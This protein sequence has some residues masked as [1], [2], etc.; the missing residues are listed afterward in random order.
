MLSGR[1]TPLCP[2]GHL[3]LKGGDRQDAGAFL[4]LKPL[5]RTGHYPI[6]SPPLRGRC[7]AGQRG[8]SRSLSLA[9]C[10]LLT[11]AAATSLAHAQS[12]LGIGSAEPGFSATGTFGSL[13][14]WINAQQQGFYRLMTGALRDMR[15]NPWAASTLVA[16]SFGY[17]V[18][19]AAGPGHGKAVISSYMLANE[20]ELKRG[21][22]L[23]FLSS[24][25]QGIVAILLVGAAFLFLRGTTVSMTDAT[26]ALETGSY[27][28][29]ALFGAWLLY[30][31]LRPAERHPSALG[32][33]AAEVHGHHDHA[34]HHHAGEVCSTCGHA[35]AP[36][37]ALL[38]GERFALREAW[39]AIVAVG[40]RPCSGA[41]IVLSFALLNG[42]YLGGLLA[43]LAMSIGT[44]ITVSTLATLAVTAKGAAVR[45]AGNGSAGQRIGTAIEIGGAALV[46]VLGLVLLGASLQA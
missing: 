32:A 34:H 10:C 41:L 8:V 37:P 35:H 11:L 21:V 9:I 16:L 29:I 31:K 46:M 15:E 30:R 6:Q 4:S 2:A 3:P 43:V 14:G 33:Q 45:F 5:R 22:L 25:L 7:P 44:A 26:R 23:S 24:I 13:F 1:D 40:L 27:A 36:D 20:I 39:S 28:L 19:H 18:F 38:K 12:P 17:G 42:L